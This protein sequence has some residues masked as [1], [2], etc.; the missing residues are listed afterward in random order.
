MFADNEQRYEMR[1]DCQEIFP[2]LLLGPFQA[3]KSLE[4]LKELGVTHV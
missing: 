4:K 1:R 2:G 3:S